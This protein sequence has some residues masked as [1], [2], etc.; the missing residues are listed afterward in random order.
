MSFYNKYNFLLKDFTAKNSTRPEIDGIFI[1]PKKTIATDSYQL[2]M[3]D[4]VKQNP[5]D[6]PVIPNK[7]KMRVD[8]KPFILPTEKAG[9]VVKLFKSGSYS[10]PILENAVVMMRGKQDVEIGR[11]DLSSYNSV[12]SRIVEGRFPET[13]DILVE[14]GKY[15]E[16]SVNPIFLKKIAGFFSS[17]TDESQKGL[18]IRVPVNG[19][20]PIFFTGERKATGQK[21]KAVLMPIKSQ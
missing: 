8:F 19:E 9:D 3:V 2:L 21:A 1:T 4:S 5:E 20:S 10:L 13:N 12:V 6:Y 14:R 18:T 17:F 11:T 15:V 7:P 16:I